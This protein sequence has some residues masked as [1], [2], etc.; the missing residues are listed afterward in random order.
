MHELASEMGRKGAEARWGSG[1]G[2][3]GGGGRSR[4]GSGRS[5]GGGGGGGGGSR[6]GGG[7]SGGRGRDDDEG[8]GRKRGRDQVRAATPVQRVSGPSNGL[9]PQEE[10]EDEG[11]QSPDTNQMR[12]FFAGAKSKVAYAF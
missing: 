10:D 8:R 11:E 3:G 1:G 6:R 7:G 5:G 9:T 12:G 2:G 4:G